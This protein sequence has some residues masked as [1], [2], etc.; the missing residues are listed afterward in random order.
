MKTTMNLDDDLLA[1]VRARATERQTTIRSIVEEALRRSLT[2]P[3]ADVFTLELPVTRG[4]RAPSV[5]VDSNAALDEY[6][7]RTERGATQA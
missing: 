4:R 1:A 2:Q 3:D 5:D 6:L 7:D